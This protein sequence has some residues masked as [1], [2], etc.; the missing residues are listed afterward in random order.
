MTVHISQPLTPQY[1]FHDWTIVTPTNTHQKL[2]CQLSSS[3]N[4][5]KTY[6]RVRNG[7]ISTFL[8]G[9][10][11]FIL[12]Q[13][14][15]WLGFT[16]TYLNP[17]SPPH[18]HKQKRGYRDETYRNHYFCQTI[19]LYYA[20]KIYAN[21]KNLTFCANVITRLRPT[22]SSRMCSPSLLILRGLTVLY[23]PGQTNLVGRA[24]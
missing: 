10:L 13:N 22:S 23:H 11:I 5:D 6:G 20:P 14:T 9:N 24:W 8:S 18:Q 17:L 21:I 16:C 4:E 2:K 7:L 3:R 1:L 19:Y 12:Q 15:I